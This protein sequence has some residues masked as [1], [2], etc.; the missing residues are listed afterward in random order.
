MKKPTLDHMKLAVSAL[1]PDD[2]ITRDGKVYR[3]D[4]VDADDWP[5]P[6]NEWE[7]LEVCRRIAAKLIY[8]QRARYHDA[9]GI[10]TKRNSTDATTEQR[11]RALYQA[12]CQ[13]RG[14][15]GQCDQCGR[16]FVTRTQL[17]LHVLYDHG[18]S[19]EA[20]RPVTINAY[21]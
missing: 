20:R 19:E 18:T 10:I 15:W 5:Q 7:W 17:C 2:L 13:E 9:L 11:I 12:V 1:L 21:K 8:S 14:N 16:K 4:M 6:V 3:K